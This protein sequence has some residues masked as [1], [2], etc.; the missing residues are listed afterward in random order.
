MDSPT[1][2]KETN[3]KTKIFR[4]RLKRV[5]SSDEEGDAVQE[6]GKEALRQ[7]LMQQANAA[8][9]QSDGANKQYLDTT[10]SSKRTAKP[11]SDASDGHEAREG[12]Q[13]GPRRFRRIRRMPLQDLEQQYGAASAASKE[14]HSDSDPSVHAGGDDDYQPLEK[15][16]K[17]MKKRINGKKKDDYVPDQVAI[18]S[19]DD[20]EFEARKK[21]P[22]RRSNKR[23]GDEAPARKK[24]APQ[25]KA[26]NDDFGN[27]MNMVKTSN[28][29]IGE[30]AN[31]D[32]YASDEGVLNDGFGVPGHRGHGGDDEDFRHQALELDFACANVSSGAGENAPMNT[33]FF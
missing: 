24:K 9:G 27:K 31:N 14:S 6:K 26:I 7:S 33:K 16:I 29:L 17:K 32:L 15:R 25:S 22:K 11:A 12:D 21:A 10:S 2:A 28:K 18:L 3:P 23:D 5:A 4:R 8:Q 1:A 13:D 30:I 19:E 20:S